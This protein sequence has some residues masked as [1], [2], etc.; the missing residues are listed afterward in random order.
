M[1][2]SSF[3]IIKNEGPPQVHPQKPIKDDASNLDTS[4][5]P[6]SSPPS[7]ILVNLI[8]TKVEPMNLLL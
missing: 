4:D 7:Y 5:I 3:I 1:A 6:L 2:Q 8:A